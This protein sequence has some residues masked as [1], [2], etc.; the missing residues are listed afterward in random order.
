MIESNSK[1]QLLINIA[2][3]IHVDPKNVSLESM[4]EDFDEWDS[5]G[6]LEIL[7]MLDS[8]YGLRVGAGD[9]SA[10]NSVQG[11]IQ[12]LEINGLLS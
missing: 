8:K 1:E 7:T 2:N 11:I 5:M 4:N 12:I 9:A 10:C 6:V 3:A